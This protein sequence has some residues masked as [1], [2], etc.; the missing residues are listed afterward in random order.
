VFVWRVELRLNVDPRSVNR[1]QP[2]QALNTSLDFGEILLAAPRNL[3]LREGAL[4]VISLA[5]V[6]RV[7]PVALC[8]E[9]VFGNKRMRDHTDRH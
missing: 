1:E 7:D 9:H 6:A 2:L 3:R 4:L 8:C 5:L